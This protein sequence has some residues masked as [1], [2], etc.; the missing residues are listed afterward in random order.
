M[1]GQG[2]GP[3]NDLTVRRCMLKQSP[4]TP[5]SFMISSLET[6]AR[7]RILL[8]G[9]YRPDRQSSMERYAD[10]LRKGLEA[11]GFDVGFIR[12]EKVIGGGVE[13]GALR[14]W[15]GYVDKYLIFPWRLRRAARGYE[16]VHICDHS[17]AMYLPS[18]G[19]RASITCHDLI[20]VNAALGRYPGHPV[21]V[22]GRVLQRWVLR[23]LQSATRI[24]S[25]S[26]KTE[27]DLRALGCPG[28][29]RVI[30]NC[31]N[32]D[33]HRVGA[34][35]I[36]AAKARCGL[37]TD[38]AYLV[39]VG[40]NQWYKNRIGVVKIFAELLK[41]ERFSTT[42][43]VMVGKS[44]PRALQDLVEELG[45]GEKVI[46]CTGASNE[47]VRALYSGADALL[48]PSLEEG[49]GWPVLEA[50]SCGCLVITSDRPP[51]TEVA[52]EAAVFV[53]P[54]DP[55]AAARAIAEATP[56][57]DDL[58]ARGPA[59]AARYDVQTIMDAYARYLLED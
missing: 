57:F 11:R 35:D 24:V 10:M 39:H 5:V 44:W 42:R 26:T 2:V 53:D 49:Y 9:N 23:H 50:Q 56:R 48:F 12:P 21:G 19:R 37:A 25:V 17:N 15:L 33:F 31:L 1:T 41:T 54:E 40:G 16:R 36:A 47:D 55:A 45:L 59:N 6:S 18:V 38:E 58:R 34:E 43:L 32:F 3:N 8:V 27:M 14:K 22:A 46:R 28:E 30:G 4:S 52:G 29:S 51:L 7:P 20:A 13:G